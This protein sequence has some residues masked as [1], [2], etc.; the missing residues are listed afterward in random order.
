VASLDLKRVLL[1]FPTDAQIR[2]LERVPA[3]GQSVS[4]LR[5]DKYVVSHVEREGAGYH[6]LCV[7]AR[8]SRGEDAEPRARARRHGG[9]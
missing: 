5:G 7:H 2:Y 8:A 6:V 9:P 3:R 4:G 1:D